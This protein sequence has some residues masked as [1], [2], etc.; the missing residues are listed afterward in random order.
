MILT[1]KPGGRRGIVRPKLRWLDD[2][3]ADI[4]TLGIKRRGKDPRQKRTDG[5]Y[6]G[7]YG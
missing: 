3:E 6:N 7:G 1:S 2:V 5:D 4:K